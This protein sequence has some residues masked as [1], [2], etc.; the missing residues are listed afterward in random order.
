METI[1]GSL[2]RKPVALPSSIWDPLSKFGFIW[3]PQQQQRRLLRRAPKVDIKSTSNPYYQTVLQTL[4]AAMALDER[5]RHL[6]LLIK[7]GDKA[8]LD[9]LLDGSNVLMHERSLDFNT[10]HARAP[11]QTSDRALAEPS[12]KDYNHEPF[13]C[14]HVVIYLY[15]LLLEQ[16][17]PGSCYGGKTATGHRLRTKVSEC[18][19]QMPRNIEIVQGSQKGT[20]KV[21][22]VNIASERAK[23]NGSDLKCRII[24]HESTCQRNEELLAQESE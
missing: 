14:D 20:I 18:V 19:E 9:L 11:C 7:T 23:L 13:L 3:T 15:G 16:L 17:M 1:K 24:L 6:K 8:D 21:S 22:W 12:N 4:N 10:C 5:T 2:K